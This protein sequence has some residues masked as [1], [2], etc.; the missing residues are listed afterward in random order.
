VNRPVLFKLALLAIVITIGIIVVNL[1]TPKPITYGAWQPAGDWIAFD[2]G[3]YTRPEVSEIYL[4]RPDGTQL[5]RITNNNHYEGRPSW[6]PNGLSIAFQSASSYTQPGGIVLLRFDGTVTQTINTPGSENSPQWS[7]DG[8]WIVFVSNDRQAR[9]SDIYQAGVGND[10][11]ERIT[12]SGDAHYPMF[13]PDGAWIHFMKFDF[14]GSEMFRIR[15]D[16]SQEQV[17]HVNI[18]PGAFAWSPDGTKIAYHNKDIYVYSLKSGIQQ[19]LTEGTQRYPF[20]GFPKWSPDQ[21]EMIF[22]KAGSLF[23]MEL[24][25]GIIHRVLSYELLNCALSHAVWHRY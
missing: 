19:A 2:C 20:Y 7:P 10:V 22:T 1:F 5:T 12:T 4:V 24:D 25:T 8:K 11:I 6:S 18:T 21:Q 15:P 17:W 23:R 16:G 13:S 9:Q 3:D 14:A